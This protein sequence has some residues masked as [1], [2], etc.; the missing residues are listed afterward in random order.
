MAIQTLL[1]A[2]K[3]L[4]KESQLDSSLIFRKQF[5]GEESVCPREVK[6]AVATISTLPSP[7]SSHLYT[8]ATASKSSTLGGEGSIQLSIRFTT[9]AGHAP[10]AVTTCARAR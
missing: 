8:G 1:A 6:N 4:E 10:A 5:Q 9:T 3:I 2:S 7:S